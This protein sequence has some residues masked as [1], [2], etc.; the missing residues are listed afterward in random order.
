MLFTLEM[1]TKELSLRGA[2]KRRRRG[3]LPV[4]PIEKQQQTRRLYR[5]I[6]TAP[7]GPRNDTKSFWDFVNCVNNNLYSER[8]Y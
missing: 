1:V 8:S 3:N 4:Q 5:E 2:A 7:T 6:A